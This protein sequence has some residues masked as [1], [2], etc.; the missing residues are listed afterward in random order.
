MCANIRLTDAVRFSRN[1]LQNPQILPLNPYPL[2]EPFE[3]LINT[4]VISLFTLNYACQ[5]IGESPSPN[6]P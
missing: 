4:A 2:L 3:A 1:N 6:Y 5:A